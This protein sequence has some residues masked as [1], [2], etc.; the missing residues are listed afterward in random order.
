MLS[1]TKVDFG[2][3][4]AIRGF[5][6]QKA[7]TA[8]ILLLNYNNETLWVVP[9]G[10]EDID[11]HLEENLY[12]IQVKSKSLTTSKLIVPDK[13]QEYSIIEK[14]HNNKINSENLN[15]KI[16][17]IDCDCI[18]EDSAE[19]TVLFTRTDT[20][21]NKYKYGIDIGK[22]EK[23]RAYKKF[24][25]SKKENLKEIAKKIYVYKTPFT[26]EL[27]SYWT[28]LLGVLT[29][30]NI[31][32][33]DHKGKNTLILI[34]SIIKAKTQIKFLNDQVYEDKKIH[35]SMIKPLIETNKM[36]ALFNECLE[37]IG[38]GILQKDEINQAKAMIAI[39]LISDR[40]YS[41]IESCLNDLSYLKSLRY[42]IKDYIDFSLGEIKKNEQIM[43]EL[44]ENDIIARIVLYYV[45]KEFQHDI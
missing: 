15:F 2:G 4:E 27:D 22:I 12:Y 30:K 32:T 13:N 1:E 5:T 6:Y 21:I 26:K 45:R 9:E 28:Y 40:H 29:G 41:Y 37:E 7:V 23:S 14:L 25:D 24:N 18:K 35:T 17:C 33:N 19:A 16:V 20:H 38:Y 8:L 10:Y 44:S 11:V 42:K 34:D 3:V 43:N 31:V 39:P 36:S